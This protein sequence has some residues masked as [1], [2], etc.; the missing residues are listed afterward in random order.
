VFVQVKIADSGPWWFILDTGSP[1]TII[2]TDL[3]GSISLSSRLAGETAGAGQGRMPLYVVG[4]A[5]VSIGGV[6]VREGPLSGLPLNSSLSK[7]QGREIM[8]LVGNDIVAR[9]AVQI[10]YAGRRLRFY[11]P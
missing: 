3:A 11:D 10:D 5:D 7:Y 9:Y 6:R 1:D 8:G 2:D 4:A